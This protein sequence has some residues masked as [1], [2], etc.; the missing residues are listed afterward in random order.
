MGVIFLFLTKIDE[1]AN[2]A[3]KTACS[4]WSQTTRQLEVRKKGGEKR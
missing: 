1:S 2:V 4:A 3:Q